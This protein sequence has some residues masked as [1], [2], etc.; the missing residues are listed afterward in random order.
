M[1]VDTHN[2]FPLIE[3]DALVAVI[4]FTASV[5]WAKVTHMDM[6]RDTILFIAKIWIGIALFGIALYFVM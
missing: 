4:G 1:K 6:N 2:L 5:L 3:V